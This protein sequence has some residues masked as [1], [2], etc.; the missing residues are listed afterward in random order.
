MTLRSI[1]LHMPAYREGA[2]AP[3][4]AIALAARLGA[5]LTVLY[6]I[7]EL[8]T[9][10]TVLGAGH[11]AVAEAEARDAP[12][13]AAAEARVREAA[14]KAGVALTFEAG[15]GNP[16]ELVTL[17][18]RCHDLVVV[19][20]SAGG[21]EEIAETRIEEAAIA[22]GT[23]TLVI[24]RTGSFTTIGR[25]VAVAWNHSRQS[26]AAVHGAMPLI[27][28]AD[29]VVVLKGADRDPTSSITRRPGYDVGAW[30]R[31]HTPDVDVVTF[32]A[33]DGEAGMK[34]LVAARGARADVLVMGAYGRS[35]WREFLF[36]G[37]TRFVVDNL[38]IPVLMAH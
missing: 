17:V 13:T 20:Q 9:L 8:A 12:L 34:L 37:A 35:S 15:E 22:C 18:G 26:A 32:E 11:P 24:P 14:G 28:T 16:L 33:S 36:G 19:E 7:P 31:Q 30:L 6:T 21:L 2:P 29:K 25:R 5:K 4:A 23:P 27:E 38:D 3:E 1:L 10:K